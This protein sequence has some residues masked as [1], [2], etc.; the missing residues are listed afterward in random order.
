[1]KRVFI[2]QD[3]AIEGKKYLTE[4]GYEIKMGNGTTEAD[5]IRDVADCDAIL[6]RTAKITRKVL[7]AGKNLKIVARH[8]AGYDNVDLQAAS[9]LGIY[10]TNTPDATTNSVAEFTLGAI[11]AVTKRTFLMNRA[12]LDGNFS[13]RNSHKGIDLQG[14]TLAIIGFGRIGRCVARKAHFG[15]EMNIIAYTP[16]NTP[17]NNTHDNIPDYVKSVSWEEALSTAD[18]VSLHMPANESNMGCFGAKE[19]AMMKNTAFFVNCARGELV[20]EHELAKAIESG[21]IAGAFV[22]VYS[23]E[24]PEADNPLLKLKNVSATPHIASNTEECMALMA[25]Q[26]ASQIHKVLS[27]EKPDWLVNNVS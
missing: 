10:V 5:L 24:P 27:G 12:L 23:P 4:R 16:H 6:L 21:E 13:Y 26:A 11:I 20:K 14:R 8:G 2:P 7:E 18:V 15:L 17:E 3:V 25:V 9:E 22:D 19:F 1:M